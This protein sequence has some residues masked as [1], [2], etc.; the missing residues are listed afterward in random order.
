MSRLILAVLICCTPAFAAIS[1]NGSVGGTTSGTFSGTATGSLKIVFAYRNAS[2]TPP[3]LPAGWTT[4]FASAGGTTNSFRVGCNVSSSSGDTG[5]GTWTNASEI[6]GVSYAGTDA[7]TTANCNTTGIGSLNAGTAS[8]TAVTST[9]FNA[10]AITVTGS[11]SWVVNFGGSTAAGLCTP[12]GMTLV[13]TQGT[14]P[15]D[16]VSDT[17]AGATSWPSTNCTITSGTWRS[18]VLQVIPAITTG[19]P[20][21]I[22][23]VRMSNLDNAG[24]PLVAAATITI[25]LPHGTGSGNAIV[26]SFMTQRTGGGLNPGTPTVS[27]DQ[28]NTYIQATT[29]N[30]NGNYDFTYVAPNVAANSRVISVGGFAQNQVIF[31]ASAAEVTNVSQIAPIDGTG[32][33]PGQ[34]TG[35]ITAGSITPT[36]VN[37]Y[38]WQWNWNET[39]AS[40]GTVSPG[41]QTNITW[42][43]ESVDT[44]QG[45]WI[46]DGV[47]NSTTALNPTNS[48]SVT[49]NTWHSQAVALKPATA[50]TADPGGME[51]Y[52]AHHYSVEANAFA[53][54]YTMQIPV[55]GDL[56]VDMFD[57]GGADPLTSAVTS[58]S[59]TVGD[60]GGTSNGTDSFV[61]A[62]YVSSPSL[63]SGALTWTI[64]QSG[65][66]VDVTH[67]IYDIKG[68]AT[69]TPFDLEAHATGNQTG[70]ANF[71]SVSITPNTSSGLILSDVAVAFNTINSCTL[72]SSLLQNGF[73][74]SNSIGNTPYDENNGWAS[75]VNTSTAS[76]TFGWSVITGL[77][78]NIGTWSSQALAF[79]APGAA[80]ARHRGAAI[81]Q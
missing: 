33:N 43:L 7:N 2:T 57:G 15:E 45:S 35:T 48:T 39:D 55:K 69:S 12:S 26:L 40:P 9:T 31:T 51:I 28:G 61:H 22:Q 50:G 18:Y 78:A 44:I 5:T 74:S 65:Y 32:C 11:T 62:V 52:W 72:A 14:G 19:T 10:P 36:R 24:Q 47:Y 34:S 63:T 64:T 46:Q 70:T 25:P 21:V 79:K 1:R 17:N 54:P 66:A 73:M 67:I 49:T 6:I 68:A 81:T 3:T 75:I 30:A 38:F 41:S 20:S 56:L 71:N 29:C 37:D 4:I 76:K 8:N 59:N 58:P 42:G 80:N 77:G 60:P 16:I 13:T 27:D 53:A 23:G